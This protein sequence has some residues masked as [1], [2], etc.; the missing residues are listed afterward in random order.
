MYVVYFKFICAM[1]IERRDKGSALLHRYYSLDT[2]LIYTIVS[3][4]SVKN[5]IYTHFILFYVYICM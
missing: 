1:G 3:C 2:Y 5:G 4:N